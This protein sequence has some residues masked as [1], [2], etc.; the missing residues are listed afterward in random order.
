MYNQR[1]TFGMDGE[2]SVR[3]PAC[4]MRSSCLSLKCWSLTSTLTLPAS[5]LGATHAEGGYLAL[6]HG[7]L[8][9]M[10]IVPEFSYAMCGQGVWQQHGSDDTRTGLAPLCSLLSI[11]LH[12]FSTHARW[13]CLRT[14]L[15]SCR[16]PRCSSNSA[17]RPPTH[18]HRPHTHTHTV[19]TYTYIYERG[20]DLSVAV[21]LVCD[22]LGRRHHP[23]RASTS[24]PSSSS[25]SSSAAA[26]YRSH[27]MSRPT[28][29][30][31]PCSPLAAPA[32][33]DDDDD[34][35]GGTGPGPS[36]HERLWRERRQSENRR[37]DQ[38]RSIA[39]RQAVDPVLRRY[40]QLVDSPLPWSGLSEEN[41]LLEEARDAELRCLWRSLLAVTEEHAPPCFPACRHRSPSLFFRGCREACAR[42]GPR[43]AG[44]YG[45]VCQSQA[46]GCGPRGHTRPTHGGLLWALPDPRQR[47]HKQSHQRQRHVRGLS[48]G[49]VRT[50]RT[51]DPFRNYLSIVY[52]W[53]VYSGPLHY[54]ATM[55]HLLCVFF[56]VSP[57]PKQKKKGTGTALDVGPHILSADVIR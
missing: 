14:C 8:Q 18:T 33:K 10:G 47:Q 48:H 46:A 21:D 7:V 23:M 39:Y 25:S 55:G 52:G 28:P 17:T 57:G 5:R 41:R 35:L 6:K 53:R 12:L 43:S 3:N 45:G 4:G 42:P 44:Q 16:T 50:Y 38:T 31:P 24:R 22:E 9:E 32:A 1:S 19:H 36:R 30:H 54:Y 15:R 26:V 13:W 51:Y 37:D 27:P 40:R 11:C 49:P 34:H 20:M 56:I 2:H 29:L